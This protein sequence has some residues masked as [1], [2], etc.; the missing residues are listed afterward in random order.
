MNGRCEQVQNRTAIADQF[1]ITVLEKSIKSLADSNRNI[2][3]AI[4][5]YAY[6]DVATNL[7]LTSFKRLSITNYLFISLNA[8]GCDVLDARGINCFHYIGEFKEGLTSS[9]CRTKGFHIK[10]NQRARIVLD[11]LRLGYNPFLVDLDIVFLTDPGPIVYPLGEQHDLVIQDDANGLINTG[12]YYARPTP[13]SLEFFTK[14]YNFSQTKLAEQKNDQRIMRQILIEFFNDT[15][16]IHKL[17]VKRFLVG[18]T[19]WEIPKR[20]F[21]YEHPWKASDRSHDGVHKR[22]KGVSLQR[23]SCMDGGYQWVLLRSEQEVLDVR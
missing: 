22:R 6:A 21:N 16:R 7:Y 5:D 4:V 17:D 3:I 19:Y 10:T 18:T 8:K 14:A 23:K 1:S 13:L 12:F 15:L 9:T 20:A 11:S 2:Y